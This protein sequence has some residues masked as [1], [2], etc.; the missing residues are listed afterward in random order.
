MVIVL[1]ADVEIAMFELRFMKGRL[2]YR[3]WKVGLDAS[4]AINP[5]P[6][7]IEWTEWENVPYY[8]NEAHYNKKQKEKQ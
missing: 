3:Q 7:P 1:L 8:L 4:G 2:Q 6:L 5:L